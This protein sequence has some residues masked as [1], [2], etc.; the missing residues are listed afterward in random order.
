M[1]QL[2]T[3]ASQAPRKRRPRKDSKPILRAGPTPPQ[4]QS[5]IENWERLHKKR[6]HRGC[7]PRGNL[8]FGVAC[9]EG[10]ASPRGGG[11]KRR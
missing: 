5:S 1:Q 10:E 4:M 2:C 3:L 6:K 7:S 11:R 8:A 9:V